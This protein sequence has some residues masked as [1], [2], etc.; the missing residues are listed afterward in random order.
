M[1]SLRK[2]IMKSDY[3]RYVLRRCTVQDVHQILEL[4]K[5]IIDELDDKGVLRKN[6]MDV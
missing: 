1:I 5:I 2:A 3:N 4:Q 6:E